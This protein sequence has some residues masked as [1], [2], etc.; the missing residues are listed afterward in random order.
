MYVPFR[1]LLSHRIK[2]VYSPGGQRRGCRIP[3]PRLKEPKEDVSVV[4]NIDVPRVGLHIAALFTYSGR[5][6][7]VSYLIA[8]IAR[9][10]DEISRWSDKLR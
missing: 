9:G 1:T 6:F 2:L 7:L 4:R 5:H 10:R 3:I 8:C